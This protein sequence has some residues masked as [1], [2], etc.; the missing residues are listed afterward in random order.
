MVTVIL[1]IGKANSGKTRTLKKFYGVDG[2]IKYIDKRIGKTIV[3]S[4]SLTSPQELR[5]FCK[6][7]LVIENLNKRLKTAEKKVKEKYNKNDF[8]FVI[9]F[10]LMEKEGSINKNCILK[11]IEN[12][13]DKGHNIHPIY[14]KKTSKNSD[15][16]E[17]MKELK[18][19]EI[20][21]RKEY[22]EQARKLKNLILPFCP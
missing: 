21:S 12:L 6:Y 11:P 20:L 19:Q 4:V 3:C 17:F 18:P 8:V 7:E 9:P 22:C 14:L 16:D 13:K 1:L 10:T 2:I 5:E 15:Y